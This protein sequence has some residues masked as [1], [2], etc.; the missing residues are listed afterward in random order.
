MASALAYLRSMAVLHNDIKPSNI[1]Y[2]RRDGAKL[3]DFGISTHDNM[4]ICTGGS[5]WYLPPE[6]QGSG[7]RRASADMFALGVVMLYLLKRIAL[8]DTQCQAK[9]WRIR[10]IV[11]GDDDSTAMTAMRSW[12]DFIEDQ[13]CQ[14]VQDM[15]NAGGSVWLTDAVGRMLDTN[16]EERLTAGELAEIVKQNTPS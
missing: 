2:S 13:R 8:P 7:E 16:P 4:S 5:P 11:A 6:F 3:I 9:A 1:L 12:L 15:E 14:L 10:D